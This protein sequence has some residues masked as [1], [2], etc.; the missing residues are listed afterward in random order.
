MKAKLIL[1]TMRLCGRKCG[2]IG[3]ADPNTA[4]IVFPR[5]GGIAYP[6]STW[7]ELRQA[8]KAYRHGKSFIFA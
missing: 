1:A 8:Y 5:N 3:Y 4:W 7:R 2:W 6:V